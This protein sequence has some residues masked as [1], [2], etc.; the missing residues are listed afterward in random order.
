[1]KCF[2]QVVIVMIS[3]VLLLPMVGMAEYTDFPLNDN[4]Y[5]GCSE[6][7]AGG[8]IT[9]KVTVDND[10]ITAIEVIEQNETRGLGTTALLKLID[11]M[12]KVNSSEV[13]S[14]AGATI[15]SNAF[16]AAVNQALEN[17]KNIYNNK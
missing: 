15:T 11:A 7:G 16:K 17:A 13:D 4:E 9:V 5:L 12:V 1:M 14:I 2:R 10:A 8:R 3:V 6:N